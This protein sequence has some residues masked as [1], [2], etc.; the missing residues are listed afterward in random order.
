VEVKRSGSDGK[1]RLE[2]VVTADKDFHLPVEVELVI[3][4]GKPVRRLL[5]HKSPGTRFE[6][7]EESSS[8]VLQV[9]VDPD[10]HI[11]G[12][13]HGALAGDIQ[14]NGEVDGIDLI[15]AAMAMGQYYEP[16]GTGN[17]VGFA[18]WA[19]LKFDGQIDKQDLDLVTHNF[20]R[21]TGD[22]Q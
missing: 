2:L 15:Y 22:K 20:G 18:D 1:H 14:L 16:Y 11:V 5:P 9:R 6:L 3:A 19:D 10:A 7:T 17:S 12:R 13:K 8:E 4:D 21:S